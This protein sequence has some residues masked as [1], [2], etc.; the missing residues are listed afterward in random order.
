MYP[1][2]EHEKEEKSA[3]RRALRHLDDLIY[4]A[5]N[6]QRQLNAGHQDFSGTAQLYHSI[7]QVA[8]NLVI[9]ETL[10]DV[11]EWHAADHPLNQLPELP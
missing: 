8:D 3:R 1:N 4:S 7:R 6:L 9:L 10:R 2:R 5:G 11:R